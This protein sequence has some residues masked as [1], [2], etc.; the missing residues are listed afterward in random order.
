M[1]DGRCRRI[2]LLGTSLALQS[3]GAV[4]EG[5]EGTACR[6]SS[7]FPPT[8]L[9]DSDSFTP[10][11]VLFDIKAG[12]PDDALACLAENR[13]LLLLGLNLE[14]QHVLILSGEPAQLSTTEDLRQILLAEPRMEGRPERSVAS[15]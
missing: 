11:V 9:A 2:L 6:T 15:A 14:T 10:D 1:H 7:H 4:I 3:V 13:D 5:I 12:I 8:G